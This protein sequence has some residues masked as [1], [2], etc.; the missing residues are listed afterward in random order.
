LHREYGSGEHRQR[1]NRGS[2][3]NGWIRI[4]VVESRTECG[5]TN[6]RE[7]IFKLASVFKLEGK[8]TTTRTYYDSHFRN[9]KDEPKEIK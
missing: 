1:K 5:M 8:N 7:P 9:G 2:F 4:S 3:Q 6:Y